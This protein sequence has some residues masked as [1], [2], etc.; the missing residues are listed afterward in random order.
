VPEHIACVSHT[1][2]DS[3]DVGHI[4]VLLVWDVEI[5]LKLFHVVG[6][7]YIDVPLVIVPVKGES[8]VVGAFPVNGYL[9]VF[10]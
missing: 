10:E 7:G 1:Q 3:I 6:H 5:F 2:V 8:T 9:V 4:A